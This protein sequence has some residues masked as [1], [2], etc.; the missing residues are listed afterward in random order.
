MTDT[1]PD[2][3]TDKRCLMVV[4][5]HPDDEVFSTG[6]I[7]AKYAAEGH[8]VVVVYCTRGEAGEMYDDR[9]D[10][11]E[12]QARLGEIREGESREACAI[13]GVTD[14]YFLGYRDSGMADTEHNQHPDAFMNAP[15]E[16]TTERLLEIVRATRPQVVVTYDESG[17]Y[18]H[19]DHIMASRT[20]TEAFKRAEAEGITQKLYYSTRSREGFRAYVE[21]LRSID[22]QIPWVQGDINFDEYGLPDAEIAAHIDIAA[23]APLKKQALAVHR[24]QIKPDFFYLQIPDDAM[25]RV[26]G[27]EYFA[28]VLPPAPPGTRE[29]DLFEGTSGQAEAA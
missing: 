19:P 27:V 17:G 3:M 13:L 23:Y 10:A 20:T 24:T 16:E 5:A 29:D 14:V 22:L 9:L 28:R 18:G 7:L 8:R 1:F 15:L 4:H 12:A 26:A 21:G 11:D 2:I 25:A 6:G